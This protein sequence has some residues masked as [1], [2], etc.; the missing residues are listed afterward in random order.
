MFSEHCNLFTE[1]TADQFIGFFHALCQNPL[2]FQTQPRYLFPKVFD[3]RWRPICLGTQP[4]RRQTPETHL[5]RAFVALCLE[6]IQSVLLWFTALRDRNYRVWQWHVLRRQKS[7]G[8]LISLG[9]IPA[10]AASPTCHTPT[11]KIRA[12]NGRNLPF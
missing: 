10:L 7:P 1:R 12:T 5:R 9:S 11:C 3:L 2:V 6:V 4:L 8:I